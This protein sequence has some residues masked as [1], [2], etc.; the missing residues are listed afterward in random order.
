MIKNN[1]KKTIISIILISFLVILF[2]SVNNFK[3]NNYSDKISIVKDIIKEKYDK[4]HYDKDYIYTLKKKEDIYKYSCFD[5]NG[6][7]LY[8]FESNKKINIIKVMKKYY[9]TY[10]GE[11]HLFNIDNKE[12]TKAKEIKSLNDYLIKVGTNI[13]N[14]DNEILFKDVYSINSYNNDNNFNINNYYLI[15]KKGNIIYENTLVKEEIKTK[16]KTDYLIIEKDNNYYTLF[17]KLDKIIG[18]GFDSYTINKNVEIKINDEKYIV[19]N[20]GLRKK[21]NNIPDKLYKKY[22]VMSDIL[23]SKYIFVMNK[24]NNYFGIYNINSNKFIK[25]KKGSINNLKKVQKDYYLFKKNDKNYLYDLSNLKIIYTSNYDLKNIIIFENNYKSINDK[26]NYYLLDNNDNIIVESDKQIVL[27]HKKI[28]IGN[29]NKKFYLYNLNNQKMTLSSKVIINNKVYYSYTNTLISN[30]FKYKYTGEYLTYYEDTII[31]Y[32]NK[33]LYFYN[34]KNNK[35]YEYEIGNGK[36]VSD[37]P[38]RNTIIVKK[39]N[40]IIFLDLKANELNEIKNTN[41]VNYYY[42][43]KYGKIIIITEDDNKE[44]SYIGE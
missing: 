42:N 25:I 8:S 1:I 11:Y 32:K 31:V 7:K 12:I 44:G 19:Y 35:E 41:L 21:I 37:K 14:I 9:I 5:L 40:N 26:D 27:E 34:L 20:N 16:Q 43:Y 10:D 28:K 2:L 4:V 30:N 15:D 29:V 24:E 38:F 39:D 6:N 36:V 18:D 33:T 3:K 22:Y 17:V 13:I 23:N